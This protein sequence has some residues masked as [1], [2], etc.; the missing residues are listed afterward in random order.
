MSEELLRKFLDDIE[1]EDGLLKKVKRKRTKSELQRDK[2]KEILAAA[3]KGQ[4][5]LPPEERFIV[6]EW[7]RPTSSD[8]S[9]KLAAQGFSLVEQVRATRPTDL[10][11]RN[12][13]Y[14]RYMDKNVSWTRIKQRKL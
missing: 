1:N 12:L 4:I 6:E 9:D 13:K 14:V 2:V 8:L 3:S 10:M 5:E 7:G 11:K